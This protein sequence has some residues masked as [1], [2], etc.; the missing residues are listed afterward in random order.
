[1][2]TLR[3]QRSL[4]TRSP[5]SSGENELFVNYC[6]REP[7]EDPRG[8]DHPNLSIKLYLPECFQ[9]VCR[10]LDSVGKQTWPGLLQQQ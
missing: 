9:I 7:D 2:L 1:M 4:E 3:S 5:R 6:C 8:S 10:N